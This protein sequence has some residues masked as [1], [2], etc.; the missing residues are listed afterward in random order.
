MNFSQITKPLSN[1]GKPRFKEL[2]YIKI[3]LNCYK[4]TFLYCEL[5]TYFHVEEL[6]RKRLEMEATVRD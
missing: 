4:K 2:L 1:T 3:D 6:L 5:V